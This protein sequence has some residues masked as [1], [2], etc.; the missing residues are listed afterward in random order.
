MFTG[1][2]MSLTNYLFTKVLN[3]T[4]QHCTSRYK[5]YVDDGLFFLYVE[6]NDYASNE[7]FHLV[8]QLHG[9]NDGEEM[10]VYYNGICKSKETI[11]F[12][13]TRTPGDGT[14]VI[15]RMYAGVD[16]G[17]GW[18]SVTVDELTLW[19]R[20]LNPVEIQALHEKYQE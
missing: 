15:G 7:W 4:Q 2:A 8:V 5:I 19:N 10:E 13:A 9:L 17:N 20:K 6:D 16:I 11:K 14:L 3:L 1:T 12:P 18:G